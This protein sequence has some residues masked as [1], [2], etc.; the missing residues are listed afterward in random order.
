MIKIKP[1]KFS[2]AGDKESINHIKNMGGIYLFYG[3]DDM[4]DHLL[5]IGKAEFLRSRIQQHYSGHSNMKDVSHNF[6]TVIGFYCDD[7]VERAIYEIYLINDLKPLLNVEH[8]YTYESQR[9]SEQFKSEKQKELEEIQQKKI[10]QVILKLN[11]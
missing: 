3:I 10:E 1:P 8:V 6:G 9:Y 5:Y 7:P 2:F 11:L 4:Q